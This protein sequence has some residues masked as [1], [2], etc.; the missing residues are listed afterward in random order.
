[1]RYAVLG[2]IHA[3]LQAFSAVLEDMV[4]MDVERVLCVGDLVGYGAHPGEC[5]QIMDDLDA[6]TVAGNH[7]WAVAG[8]M[9][10]EYFNADARDA[11]EWTRSRISQEQV[12][13]LAELP[14][15][16]VVDGIM[17]VHSNPFAPE[18]FDYIQTHYDVQLT[19]EHLQGRIGFVGHSHVPVMFANIEPV[20]CFL[21]E[22]YVLDPD[23]RVVVNVG[24]VGQP[25]DMDP[26]ACYVVYDSD[27]G[28][29]IMRR[30]EYDIHGAMQSIKDVGLPPTNGARLLL[31]R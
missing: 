28:V 5:M 13:R 23:V 24:S 14:L 29:V 7:D 10:V 15:C 25:R 18:F 31:G 30:V 16:A 26:R 22:E 1:M 21:S 3:N 12:E 6:L 8:R 9:N 27:E 11:V 19:F 17:L 20:S 4:E 2:D